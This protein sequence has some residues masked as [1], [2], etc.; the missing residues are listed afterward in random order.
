MPEPI[1]KS[2]LATPTCD[3]DAFFH[4]GGHAQVYFIIDPGCDPNAL[5]HLYQL[6]LSFEPMPLLLGTDLAAL[7]LQGAFG[8][9]ADVRSQLCKDAAALCART[10]C[11]MVI[12]GANS[13]AALAHARSLLQVNDS[14][15]GQSLLSVGNPHLWA[16]L[17]L[18]VGPAASRLFG[19]I[20]QVLTPAPT[21]LSV[22]EHSWYC[23][24]APTAGSLKGAA[25]PL[26][27]PPGFAA[28]AR[29][30]HM[31]YWLDAHHCALGR[32]KAD[33]LPVLVANLEV[34][35]GHDISE[36]RYLLALSK[37]VNGPRLT[38]DAR[39]MAILQSQE[40]D[41][42]KVERLARLAENTEQ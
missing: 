8:F 18:S 34:L 3:P 15:G 31:L 22:A 37:Q 25:R 33:R 13:A 30:L 21:R 27:L 17:A 32:P 40:E 9:A 35:M 26:D 10:R 2:L 36:S 28:A 12:T 20:T 14:S 16:A 11:G 42:V 29:T 4:A 23:W 5:A 41:F 39:A 1:L 7:A 6:G 24:Q 38:A 19:P